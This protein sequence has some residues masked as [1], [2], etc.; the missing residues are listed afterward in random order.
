MVISFNSTIWLSASS[1]DLVRSEHE[2][3]A[4]PCAS[5][6]YDISFDKPTDWRR[7]FDSVW[8]TF[9]TKF[10]PVLGSLRRH[11]E[12]LVQVKLTATY[13]AVET[14]RRALQ[15][16]IEK[17]NEELKQILNVIQHKRKQMLD[18]L[19]SQGSHDD[20]GHRR[21]PDQRYPT[22]GDWI[23]EERLFLQWLDPHDLSKDLLYL[24]GMPGAGKL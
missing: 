17:S 23:M 6:K 16:T 8:K 22:S 1:G 2:V 18:K 20:M 3:G 11:R 21:L 13:G 14:T 5:L 12:L 9:R 15:E 7:I 19:G 24:N 10:S 4:Y